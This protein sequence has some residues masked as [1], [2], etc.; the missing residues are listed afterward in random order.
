MKRAILEFNMHFKRL[1]IL[2]I[3]CLFDIVLQKLLHNACCSCF[4]SFHGFQHHELKNLWD[5]CWLSGE[6]IMRL[7]ICLVF[8]LLESFK[9]LQIGI[10]SSLFYV[11]PIT[12]TYQTIFSKYTRTTSVQIKEVHY[13][14]RVSIK[15]IF[16]E[17]DAN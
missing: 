3:L 2:C 13:F 4:N 12:D 10:L 16:S 6:V 11:L 17:S 1:N 9:S 7:L 14:I 15:E 5:L 8:I